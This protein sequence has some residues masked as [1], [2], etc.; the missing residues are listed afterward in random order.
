MKNLMV[1]QKDGTQTQ[2]QRM[3]RRAAQET[4]ETQHHQQQHATYS[5]TNGLRV[6]VL[7]LSRSNSFIYSSC[8]LSTPLLPPTYNPLT[9]HPSIPLSPSPSFSFSLSSC[10]TCNIILNIIQ[11]KVNN[12]SK[13]E[14]LCIIQTTRSG[15]TQVYH[16]L[17]LLSS[18]LFVSTLL[19]RAHPT[20]QIHV[21]LSKSQSRSLLP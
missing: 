12:L 10:F 19:S 21:I 17:S 13:P 4:Q 5:L 20:L 15:T 9:L 3:R 11:M 8:S 18:L 2:T 6:Q 7:S 1:R 14:A 16:L